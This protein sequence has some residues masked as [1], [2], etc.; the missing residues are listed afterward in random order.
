MRCPRA[1]HRKR[2]QGCTSRRMCPQSHNSLCSTGPRCHRYPCRSRHRQGRTPDSSRRCRSCLRWARSG[3][4]TNGDRARTRRQRRFG[5]RRH[6]HRERHP[7]RRRP[8]HHPRRLLSWSRRG[9]RRRAPTS[10]PASPKPG[11]RPLGRAT[12]RR[13]EGATVPIVPDR[14]G[15]QAAAVDACTPTR[16][17]NARNGRTSRRADTSQQAG[18]RCR[19]RQ[20]VRR[21]LPGS[22]SSLAQRAPVSVERLREY[23]P[24]AAPDA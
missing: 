8:P 2:S 6:L 20:D 13:Q 9:H 11:R 17:D 14:P 22:R 1:P 12:S 15:S 18:R 19:R 3:C 21:A 23:G 4:R 10:G 7:R 24:A 16:L 5:R